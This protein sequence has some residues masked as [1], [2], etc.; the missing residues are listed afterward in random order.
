MVV[1]EQEAEELSLESTRVSTT[2]LEVEED[3]VNTLAVGVTWLV[4]VATVTEVA[5]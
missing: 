2:T 5:A 3:V 4:E 1:E